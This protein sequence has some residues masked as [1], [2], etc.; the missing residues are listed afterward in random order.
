[1]LGKSSGVATQIFAEQPKAHCTHYHTHSLS[2]SVID[3]TKNTKIF[4]DTIGTEEEIAILIKYSPRGENIIGS[5]K[6]QIECENDSDFR[7]RE[8]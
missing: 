4:R 2:L 1:M 3:V 8:R 7:A 5:I 6:E